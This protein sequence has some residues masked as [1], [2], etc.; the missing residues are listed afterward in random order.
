MRR[1]KDAP[2]RTF[3]FEERTMTIEIRDGRWPD[4]S[5]EMTGYNRL[6]R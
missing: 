4:L 5:P 6:L 2:Y 1:R 3:K